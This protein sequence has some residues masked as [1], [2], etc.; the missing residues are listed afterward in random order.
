MNGST[1]MTLKSTGPLRNT[2]SGKFDKSYSTL[3]YTA[4][5]PIPTND[6]LDLAKEEDFLHP[7]EPKPQDYLTTKVFHLTGQLALVSCLPLWILW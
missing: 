4:A 7:E 3:R 6:K 2:I 5:R 1:T